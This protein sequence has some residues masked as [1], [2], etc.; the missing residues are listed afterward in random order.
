MADV[1]KELREAAKPTKELA[2]IGIRG[3]VYRKTKPARA[4][5]MLRAANELARRAEI[6]E[7][8]I[9]EFRDIAESDPIDNALDPQRNPRVARA[10]L[11]SLEPTHAE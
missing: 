6:I 2:C 1:E 3:P 5:L 4:D 9:S 8:A 10:F 11:A 7:R